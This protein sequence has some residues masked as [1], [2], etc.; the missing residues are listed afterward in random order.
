M[1]L[2]VEILKHKH[3]MEKEIHA[4][5]QAKYA[6][7]L[8][9]DNKWKGET[10]DKEKKFSQAKDEWNDISKHF[11]ELGEAKRKVEVE[12][13]AYRLEETQRKSELKAMKE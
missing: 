4:S 7:L 12:M 11:Q 9:K 13:E 8:A 2:G 10:I 5:T 1:T 3:V 6:M